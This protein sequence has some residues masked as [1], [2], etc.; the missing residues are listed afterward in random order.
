QKFK[1]RDMTPDEI[2]VEIHK[3]KKDE[4]ISKRFGR[5]TSNPSFFTDGN[6]VQPSSLDM[7]SI[8]AE[9]AGSRK[10]GGV[11]KLRVKHPLCRSSLLLFNASTLRNAEEMKKFMKK[12]MPQS[13]D[14]EETECNEY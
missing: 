7:T 12:Q 8:W 13:E 5:M 14:E 11:Y 10:S 2:V 4:K 6:A 9:V 3:K 1:G